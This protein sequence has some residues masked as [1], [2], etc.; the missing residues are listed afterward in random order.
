[1]RKILLVL[2]IF[3]LLSF[4]NTYAQD[5]NDVDL[6][7]LSFYTEKFQRNVT[8]SAF[9]IAPE[10]NL[11]IYQN[12]TLVLQL[13]NHKKVQAEIYAFQLDSIN[14][15]ISYFGRIENGYVQ[16]TANKKIVENPLT[17]KK[18]GYFA[19]LHY[20]DTATSHYEYLQGFT[21]WIPNIKLESTWLLT[22]INEEDYLN[23]YQYQLFQRLKFNFE[24]NTISGFAGCSQLHGKFKAIDQY[25]EIESLELIKPEKCPFSIYENMFL[26]M[27]RNKTFH[28][29][30]ENGI[31]KLTN[32]ENQLL[33]KSSY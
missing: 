16:F 31:L 1:M 33:F 32:Q 18:Y 2:E 15:S 22:N 21:T 13:P 14:Q 5:P 24:T 20:H 17:S 19:E 3:Y 11:E 30:I 25:L 4:Q 10:W 29:T 27:L 6:N 7:P 26:M 12:N 9:G 23:K 8:L 28:Y